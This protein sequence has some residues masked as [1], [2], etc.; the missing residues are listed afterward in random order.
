VGATAKGGHAAL[1][2]SMAVLGM[3]L[4]MKKAFI[5]IEKQ[6]GDWWRTL[7][8]ESMKQAGEGEKAIALSKSNSSDEPGITVIVDGS[9]SKCAHKHSY[10]AKSDVGIIIGKETAI[11]GSEEQILCSMPQCHREY[12]I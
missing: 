10:N 4:L 3:P 7:L 1:T 9:W 2:E 6:I 11:Y 12:Y 5:A 8:S